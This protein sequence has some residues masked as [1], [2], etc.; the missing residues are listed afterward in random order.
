MWTYGITT[1]MILSYTEMNNNV[2]QRVVS[3]KKVDNNGNNW[4]PARH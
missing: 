1:A 2:H 3:L 4:F